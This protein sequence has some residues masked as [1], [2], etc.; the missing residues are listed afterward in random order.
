MVFCGSGCLP[1][2]NL[3][4]CVVWYGITITMVFYHGKKYGI[5][6][7]KGTYTVGVTLVQFNLIYTLLYEYKHS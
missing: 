2:K 3:V 7:L 6:P 4:W 1:G 5:R